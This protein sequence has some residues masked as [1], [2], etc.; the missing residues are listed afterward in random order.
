MRNVPIYFATLLLPWWDTH[1][2]RNLPW[3]QNPTLYR[4]W[5]SEVMLQQTQVATVERYYDRFIASF[6]DVVALADASADEVLH[7]WSGLGYYGRA[8]NLHRAAQRVRDEHGGE[9][10]ASFDA[11]ASLPGVGRST[12]GAILALATGERHAIL[13]GN[14]KRVLSRLYRVET[15][16]DAPATLRRLWELAEANTPAERVAHYTQAIM[17]LGATLCTRRRPAC[18]ICPLATCCEAH[19]AGIA[20]QLPIARARRERPQRAVVVM[21]VREGAERVLLEKRPSEGIWGGLWGLPEVG[22]VDDVRA[23]CVQTLGGAPEQLRVRP[24]LRH[25]FTHFDLDMTP[26][27]VDVR[28]HGRAMD[29]DRWLWYNV[30]E[31]ARVGLA[32]P[33]TKLLNSLL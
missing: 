8:R 7:T 27:E 3:Q 19:L 20:E 6:P 28:A 16:P 32:A 14:V 22:A 5:V 17:D 15:P 1:G 10:P 24:V 31:P 18:A 9:V 21:L 30:R 11:L 2:R 33:V 23:W 25:G 29:G 12:A 13:D 4:V 26:V